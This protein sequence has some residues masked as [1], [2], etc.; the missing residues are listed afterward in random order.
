M[1]VY[2]IFLTKTDKLNLQLTELTKALLLYPNIHLR[3]VNPLEFSKG[4]KLQNFFERD[5][6]SKSKYRLAHTSDVMRILF[7]NKYGGQYLDLDIF[8]LIPISVI[9]RKNFACL[10]SNNKLVNNCIMN[11]DTDEFGGKAISN[12]YLE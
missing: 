10:Q 7:L 6:L 3:F 8:S 1:E 4:T 11:L 5:E 12:K 2:F 9:N